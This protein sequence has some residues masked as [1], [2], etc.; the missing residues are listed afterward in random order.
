MEIKLDLYGAGMTSLHRVGLAG[1][2]LTLKALEKKGVDIDGLKWELERERVLLKFTDAKPKPALEKLLKASFQIDKDGFFEFPALEEI[3]PLS[4][5]KKIILYEALMNTFLQHGRNRKLDEKRNL[6]VD[7]GDSILRIEDFGPLKEY[8]H[9]KAADEFFAKNGN[10]KNEISIKGWLYPGGAV[11]HIGFS[12]RTKLTEPFDLAMCLLYTPVGA[13]YYRIKSTA[14]GRKTRMAVVIPEI[15][16]LEEYAEIREIYAG[17]EV[18]DLFVSSPSDAGL[19]FLIAAESIIKSL[20]HGLLDQG[21]CIVISFGIVSWN[22]KQKTRTSYLNLD[23]GKK[24]NLKDYRYARTHLRNRWIVIEKNEKGKESKTE[25]VFIVTSVAREIIADN[26]ANNR[27]W[28]EGFCQAFANPDLR[29]RLSFRNERRGLYNML[30]KA[31][32][33]KAEKVFVETCQEAWRRRLGQLGERAKKENISFNDLASREMER[34]R[35]SLNR[36]KNKTALRETV[37]DFWAR[38]GSLETLQGGWMEVMGLFE[39]KD[40]KKAR[41]LALL[42]IISYQPSDKRE[43]NALFSEKEED[44]DE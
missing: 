42:A 31:S 6:I 2:F 24:I 25:E 41:D 8:Q 30:E 16:D 44:I 22:E 19:K 7:V 20:Q 17:E 43:E 34:L 40:W 28:Y 29:K 13:F 38:A 10:L 5:A 23:P 9:Q 26:C 18:S 21:G 37:V 35:T 3:R 11:K 27:K 1:L 4:K 15:S 32:L 12:N 36:G 39:E 33:G 14:R